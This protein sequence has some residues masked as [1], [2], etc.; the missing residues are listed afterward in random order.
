MN[1]YIFGNEDLDYDNLPIR[2]LPE[3]KK[4]FPQ[5]TFELKDPNEEFETNDNLTIIDTVHGIDKVTTFTDL[6]QFKSAPHISMH[7]F[8]L[9]S[10][11]AFMQKL[12]KLK[13]FK[14]IG[15]PKYIS[16][17]NALQSLKEIF[18]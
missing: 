4:T 7:D 3:L 16:E 5:I 2:I 8:D 6:A 15:L 14:I 18:S 1:I 12:E 13:Q 17:E 10:K 9:Y 11:L